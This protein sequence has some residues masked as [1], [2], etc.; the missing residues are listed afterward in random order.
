MLKVAFQRQFLY[1]IS[2]HRVARWAISSYKWLFL[3][4]VVFKTCKKKSAF[5]LCFV[6]FIE[7]GLI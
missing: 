3:G 6:A 7:P 2:K 4:F 5:K 1:F